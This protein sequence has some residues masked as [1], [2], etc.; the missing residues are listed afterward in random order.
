MESQDFQ[1]IATSVRPKLM[2]LCR[3]F[4]DKQELAYDAEDAVQETLLRLWQMQDRLSDYQKP[5][6]LAMLI[7]K[8]VCI[9]ILK[10]NK[11]Q[12]EPLDE[13]CNIIGNVQADQSTITHDTE[14]IISDALAKLPRTQQRMLMMRAEG[15]SMVEIATTC[16]A[17][18]NAHQ[19]K[20]DD[21]RCKKENDGTLKDREEQKMT[22]L[23]DI[24]K[25]RQ[26]VEKYLNAETTIEEERMLHDF[27]SHAEE[28]LTPEDEDMRLL[29]MT[30]DRLKDNFILSDEKAE[31]FDRLMDG[32][33]ERHG[34]TISLYWFIPAAA[35]VIVFFLLTTSQEQQMI[36]Q[37]PVAMAVPED[38]TPQK[39]E[40][41]RV[42][43]DT[44]N[45]SHADAISK[46]RKTAHR[47]KRKEANAGI[48]VAEMTEAANY[49]NEQ[50]ESYQLRPAGDVMIVT[51]MPKDGLSSSYIIYAND[52]GHSYRVMP[53][54]M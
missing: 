41:Q 52:E 33:P 42:S 54:N 22:N 27:Y 29:M 32:K 16:N 5:E 39:E 1:N 46:P 14:R 37:N 45:A 2:N 49:Q 44:D 8:N 47:H 21:L 19:H 9:D 24:T 18:P 48:H 3:S 17:T 23:N 43:E 28:P 51:K 36:E 20:D 30:T 40:P 25:R 6:A 35:A 7:A 50:V 12:H 11:E 26:L 38:I 34:K 53:I 15:M 10:L 31:E 13:T 4:F